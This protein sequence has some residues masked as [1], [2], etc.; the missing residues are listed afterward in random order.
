MLHTVLIPGTIIVAIPYLLVSSGP[1]LYAFSALPL[2]VLGGL[3]VLVGIFVGLWC[4]RHFL[5]LGQGTPNPLDPPKFLVRAGPYQVVRNPMYVSVG[6]ILAGEALAH[7]SG[8]L[9][10]YLL[11]VIVVFHLFVV[12]YEE[13]TLRRLFGAAYEEYCR[14]VPRWIPRIAADRRL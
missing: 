8:T 4:T 13:P 14:R 2:R 11:L 3:S 5:V 6:L 1:E 10:V 9:V 7:G 12:L